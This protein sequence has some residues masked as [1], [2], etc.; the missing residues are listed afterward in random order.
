MLRIALAV[1]WTLATIP[2][3]LHAHGMDYVITEESAVV[4]LATFDDGDPMSY[5]EVEIHGPQ[6]TYDYQNGRT[7]RNGR[8]AFLPDRPGK[9]S[10]AVDAGMGHR[11]ETRFVVETADNKPSLK[12]EALQPGPH[13]KFW[14]IVTGFG[15]I[16]GI[17]GVWGHIQVLRSRKKTIGRGFYEA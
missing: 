7:D 4:I 5:S 14:G 16:F 6:D 11:I 17:T 8:F 9:W 3:M 2:G 15:V 12:T 1:A 10:I 13:S